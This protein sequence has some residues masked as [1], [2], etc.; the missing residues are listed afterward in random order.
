LSKVEHRL[1]A[2]VV[3]VNRVAQWGKPDGYLV[4]EA[5]TSTGARSFSEL[6]ARGLSGR[7]AINV[8]G[9]QVSFHPLT[10]V[11]GCSRFIASISPDTVIRDD[12]ARSG[13]TRMFL[14]GRDRVKS[15]ASPSSSLAHTSTFTVPVSWSDSMFTAWMSGRSM[16][17]PGISYRSPWR[18]ISFILVP[19]WTLNP[20]SLD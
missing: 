5:D 17:W 6:A 2:Q 1:D 20:A 8:H 12:P 14:A 19:G 11:C 7:L 10:Y 3:W 15:Y 13:S 9:E 18:A 16:S 4:L